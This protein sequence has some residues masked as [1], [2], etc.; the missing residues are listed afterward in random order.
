MVVWCF[1]FA[2][3]KGFSTNLIVENSHQPFFELTEL[4]EFGYKLRAGNFYP[5][6]MSKPPLSD[7]ER[8]V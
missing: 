2:F 8:S 3:L 6:Y 5:K 1:I 4:T 7:T